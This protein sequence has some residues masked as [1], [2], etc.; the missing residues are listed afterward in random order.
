MSGITR[1]KLS[2]INTAVIAFRDPITV[3]HAGATSADVDIGF[4]MNRANGLLA[5]VAIYWS[6]S[7]NTFVTAFTSNSGATDS[8][9][10]PNSYAN[11]TT[12][13]I[14]ARKIYTNDGL[15]WAGN[16][17]VIV[18]GGGGGSTYSNVDV[19]AYIGSNIGSINSN[20]T[21]A[22]SSITTFNA[23][24]GAY[25][26]YANTK[27]G[28]NTNGNLVVVATTP[29]TDANTG[30]LVVRGGAGIGGDMYIAGNIVPAAN[31]TYDLGSSSTWF[32]DL[33]LSAGTIHIGGARITQDPASGAI[34]IVPK[35]TAN[36]PNPRAT[37]FSATGAVITANTA[38]G[39]IS[40]ETIATAAASTDFNVIGNLT[41]N[42]AT[43]AG[44][45]SAGKIYTT[46]G[47]YWAGNGVEFSSG[48]SFIESATPPAAPTVGD[49]W[50]NTTDDVLYEFIANYWVD[51]QSP[52]IG[53]SDY[54][55][56]S[57]DNIAVTANVTTA[58]VYADRFFYSNGT[59]FSSSNYGNTQVAAYLV[60]NPQGS[61]YGDT[62]VEAYLGAN[63]G[64]T[65][66]NITTLF[67]NAATQATSINGINAN[68]GTAT[69][70]INTTNANIGAFQTYAN[71]T[72]N[73]G[74]TQVASYFTSN[75][76][77][78][79]TVTSSLQIPRGTTAERPAGP[80]AGALRYNTTLG[81]FEGYLTAGGWQNILSDNY[82]VEWLVV[83]GG[84]GGGS[85]HGG[86][87]GA[88]GFRTGTAFTVSSGAS[89]TVTVGAGGPGNTDAGTATAGTNGYDSVFSTV[90]STGGGAGGGNTFNAVSNGGS[91]GGGGNGTAGGAVTAITP[92]SGE[93]TSIQGYAGGSAASPYNVDY[94]AAGGGGAGG[95]GQ[96]GNAG[97]AGGN[98][99]TSAI[100]GTTVTYA[101]GG[102]GGAFQ[103]LGAGGAGGD[104]G[105]SNVNGGRGQGNNAGSNGTANTGTGGGGGGASA[106][107]NGGSGVVIV[108]YPGSQKGTGGTVTSSGGYTIHT[109][110][111]SGT[112]AA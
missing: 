18:T 6:E 96:N 49:Q 95:V 81:R 10:V 97:K 13:N 103:G 41:A 55:N 110:T 92:V 59:A 16:G 9:I 29:S 102:G 19:E 86:G 100:T 25:Q 112:F 4:L 69:T 27:I 7:G 78:I 28:T 111:G 47:L 40:S 56:V 73:Y 61:T 53:A 44:N 68:L 11:F 54:N 98:G 93:T 79:V 77:G 31:V 1:P 52:T 94:W 109:F 33:W 23:N 91:G 66:T 50:Y 88:G 30:A 84:G 45:V 12:G 60:A 35:A 101:C 34:A 20:V 64:S 5:N 106:G 76:S 26:T 104:G 74:N 75:T 24:L 72:F 65:T 2:Q 67:S 14:Y 108:R 37:V 90:T 21:A 42:T 15:Y 62:N 71:A 57:V 70:N 87:G 32:R 83:A 17:D 85:R 51:I 38:G 107:F 63:L 39:V 99:A 36:N 43:I 48:V 105:S 3:I 46:N 22:N 8:N 58:N 80:L 89:Y 82:T